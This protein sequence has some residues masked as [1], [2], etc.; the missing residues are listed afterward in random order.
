MPGFTVQEF[1]MELQSKE[2]L[3]DGIKQA[4][5]LIGEELEKTKLQFVCIADG[6]AVL[7]KPIGLSP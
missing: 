5:V 1:G 7:F 6:R 3:F 2:A 4:Q